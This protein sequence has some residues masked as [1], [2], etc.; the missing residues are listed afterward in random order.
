MDKYVCKVTTTITTDAK[1]ICYFVQGET[2]QVTHDWMNLDKTIGINGVV[3]STT[4]NTKYI[5]HVFDYFYAKKEL[6]QMNLNTI[7]NESL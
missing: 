1:N 5:Y 6:R 7:L 3:F 4:S 2:Y